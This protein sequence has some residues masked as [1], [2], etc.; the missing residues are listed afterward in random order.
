MR[1]VWPVSEGSI[2]DRSRP[3]VA[4]E[5]ISDSV[6]RESWQLA[7]IKIGLEEARCGDFAS[8]PEV[9]AVLAKYQA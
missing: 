7:E 9:A 6:E 4:N 5:S 2:L 1:S 3:Y 8:D